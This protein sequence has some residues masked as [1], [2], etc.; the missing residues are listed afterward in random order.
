MPKI[1]CVTSH[2]LDGPEQGASLRARSVFK[3]LAR[4]G[5]VHVALASWHDPWGEHPNE[6]CGGFKLVRRIRFARTPNISPLDR[7]RHEL[8][9]RFL[10]TDWVS[11]SDEDRTWLEKALG[12]YDLIWIHGVHIA[13]RFGRWHWPRT[14][15]DIDDIPSELYRTNL[16]LAH[17]IKA[18]A[19]CRW[20][21]YLWRRSEKLFPERFA[22]LCVCSQPDRE[23]FDGRANVHVVPNGFAVPEKR[24]PRS[25]ARPPRVGFIGN[26]AHGPNRQGIHWF[27]KTIWPL[28]RARSPEAE[29]RIVGAK[30]Q[31]RDWPAGQ[32]IQPLGWVAEVEGEMA[33][34][35]LTVVPILAGGGTRVKMAEAFGRRCPVV[36]T[37]LGAYGYDVT[38]GQDIFI[39]DDVEGFAGRCLELME[40]PAA[41]ERLAE[42]AWGKF[43]QL[44]TWE[45]QAGR[46]AAVV[47]QA[48]AAPKLK[49]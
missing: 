15:L 5:E 42:N 31:E 33:T 44:W 39:A 4:H 11:P 32:G 8:D 7:L 47:E 43:I 48:L 35:A 9:P 41:G 25:P 27:V 30:S 19:R 45:A 16:P 10:N 38:D 40:N 46:I 22:A 2:D 6:T 37:A 34:W 24:V 20:R 49:P 3:L 26:F 18:K 13:N 28:I 23:K 1:L 29:L 14:I 17:G 36:S 21:G 12:D